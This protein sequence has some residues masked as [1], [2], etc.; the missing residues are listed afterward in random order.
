MTAIHELD[1]VQTLV[2]IAARDD[3]QAIT[4]GS[5][6]TVV[7]IATRPS[8]AYLVEFADEYGRTLAMPWMLP[9]QLRAA[10]SCNRRARRG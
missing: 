1:M 7:A 5:V 6:G 3:D 4:K 10:Q 9:G 2:D 8:L